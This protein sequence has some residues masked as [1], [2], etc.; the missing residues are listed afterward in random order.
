MFYVWPTKDFHWMKSRTKMSFEITLPAFMSSI[1][2]FGYAF[3]PFKLECFVFL[4]HSLHIKMGVN[5]KDVQ[6]KATLY[7]HV[8]A[9]ITGFQEWYCHL[10][11]RRAL[12]LYKVYGN[13]ALLALNWQIMYYFTFATN[14]HQLR[15]RKVLLLYCS[16][17]QRY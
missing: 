9:S 8:L 6:S 5:S 2:L 4:F 1:K 15:A 3:F 12:L 14:R 16:E 11:T 17:P 13:N 10:R 7:V